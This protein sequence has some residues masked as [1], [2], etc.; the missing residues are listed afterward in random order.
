M[1]IQNEG[2]SVVSA[3]DFACCDLEAPIASLVQIDMSA[4]SAAYHHAAIGAAAPCDKVYGLLKD[5]SGIYLSAERGTIWRPSFAY[6]DRRSMIPSDIKGEQSDILDAVLP[7]LTHPAL[8]AR[9]ADIVWTNDMRKAAVAAVAVEG[10]C[11]CVEGLMNGS[12]KAAHPVDGRDLVDAVK[13]AQRALQIAR[14]TAKS[15]G[16]LPARVVSVMGA[17]Y[18]NALSDAQPVIF[19]RVA[20]LCVDNKIVEAQRAARDLEL[21]TEVAPHI[22]PIAIRGALDF[23]SILYRKI[24][25]SEGEQRCQF[26]AVLQT[27]RMR[28]ECGDAGAKASWIMEALQRLRHIRSEEARALEEQL[29]DELRRFQ[30]ASLLAMQ[31]FSFNVDI[32]QERERIVELFSQM[33]FATSLKNFALLAS[34]PKMEDLKAEALREAQAS[35]LSSLWA[36]KNLDDEGKTIV[37]TPGVGSGEP[38]EEWYLQMIARSE[39]L[40]RAFVVA[41]AI[42]PVRILINGTVAIEERHLRHLVFLSPFVPPDQAT[43]YALGFARF[44][45][46]DL[47]SA[48]YLLFPR[49]EP[50]LRHILRVNGVDPVRRR[51]NGT[52]EDQSLDAMIANHREPL[53]HILGAP[54]LDELNRI[55]NIQPGPTFRHD[56]AHGQ[57]T[58]GEC[59]SVHAV[60]ACWLLYRVCCL[61]LIDK[62]DEFVRPGL[63]V[64]EP[65]R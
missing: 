18:D 27:L 11:D 42:D 22:Y 54:L 29:E 41:N 37:Y 56:T 46:G 26:A 4:I 16:P 5:I 60:Y 28:D 43:L 64:E 39:S 48:A 55:F 14:Q 62:W 25:D 51:E 2:P 15:R 10:Y 7:R 47:A 58:D 65:G 49:L 30:R 33:D 40:R 38:P 36:V 45:Q 12:L 6:A 34:S 44:F 53:V 24:A 50:S 57:L 31:A 3:S 23:A 19:S 8:R 52:E 17:L 61:F 35:P 63:A 32:P 21:V 13:P 1:N 20:Q 59:Y 9:L